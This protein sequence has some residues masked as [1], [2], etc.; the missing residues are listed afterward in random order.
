MGKEKK[1]SKKSSSKPKENQPKSDKLY[2]ITKSNG[3]TIQ[4]SGNGEY[5]KKLYESKGWKVEEA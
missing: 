2:N 1:E 3:N 5:L 4:R